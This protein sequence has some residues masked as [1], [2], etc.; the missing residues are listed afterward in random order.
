MFI[1]PGVFKKLIKEAWEARV[2][3]LSQKEGVLMIQ[4]GYWIVDAQMDVIPYKVRATGRVVRHP[5]GR[6][7]DVPGRKGRSSAV[8]I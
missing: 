6:G 3:I 8:R 1:N 7:H 5:S 2:L 4:G